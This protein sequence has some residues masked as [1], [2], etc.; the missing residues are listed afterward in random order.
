VSTETRLP[1]CA[2]RFVEDQSEFLI[3]TPG[4]PVSSILVTHG[5]LLSSID[6][7]ILVL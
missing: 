6:R 5:R 4:G 7:K 3:A 2:L 1:G